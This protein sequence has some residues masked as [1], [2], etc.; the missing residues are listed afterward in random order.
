MDDA[1]FPFQFSEF[2]VSELGSVC[3]TPA[4]QTADKSARAV[5]AASEAELWGAVTFRAL[6]K[7]AH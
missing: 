4:L 3:E 7:S 5:K 6:N 2:T 1:R